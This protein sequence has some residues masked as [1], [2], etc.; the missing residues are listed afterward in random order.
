M[1][2]CRKKETKVSGHRTSVSLLT[3]NI[4][5]WIGKHLPIHSGDVLVP[6]LC[7]LQ[8][9]NRADLVLANGALTAFEIKS[10]RDRMD[11]WADQQDAY[12]GVFDKVWLCIHS[13]HLQK[14][15]EMLR[16]NVGLIISDNYGGLAV[17]KEAK[18]NKL[19]RLENYAELLWRAEID[20]LLASSGVGP[21]RNMRIKEARKE[22]LSSV[23]EMRVRKAV[24]E[25]IKNRYPEYQ[26]S[27]S[28]SSDKN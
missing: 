14:A 25:A 12:L 5:Q 23:P 9:K 27:S 17:L 13:R 22:M 28:S 19:Q 4:K 10:D 8:R 7:F 11:R 2:I 3:D 21:Q 1:S 16:P 18:T 24:I 15:T 26:I 20:S 6:E